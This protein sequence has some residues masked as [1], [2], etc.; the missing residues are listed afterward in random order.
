MTGSHGCVAANFLGLL[1]AV[2]SLLPFGF[3]ERRARPR[4]RDGCGCSGLRR[5]LRHISRIPCTARDAMDLVGL[6]QEDA[7]SNGEFPPRGMSWHELPA[8]AARASK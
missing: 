3:P 7:D 2:V 5:R 1:R 4:W 8:A 6:A